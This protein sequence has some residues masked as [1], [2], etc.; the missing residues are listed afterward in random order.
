M[1]FCQE[2]LNVINYSRRKTVNFLNHLTRPVFLRV[3]PFMEMRDC[4]GQK[5]GCDWAF[6]IPEGWRKLVIPFCDDMT[7]A[8]KEDGVDV[9]RL[10]IHS[11]KKKNGALQITT[12]MSSPRISEIILVYE[13]LSSMFCERC[14]DVPVSFT[15]GWVMPLCNNCWASY[16]GEFKPKEKNFKIHYKVCDDEG[17]MEIREINLEP[18]YRKVIDGKR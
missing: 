2:F 10:E 11:V 6:M 7:T 9:T 5:T 15:K 8:A 12:N 3:Y 16:M 1:G 14:G 17:S 4:D 18:Y 13:C